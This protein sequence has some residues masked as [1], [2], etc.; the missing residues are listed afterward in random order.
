MSTGT[1]WEE[2]YRSG[3]LPWD[4]G[5]ASPALLEALTRVP[6]R[7][8]VLV[9]GCGLGHDVRALAAAGAEVVGLDLSPTGLRAA[10]A[11]PRVGNEQ[12]VVGNFFELPE[13]LGDGVRIGAV[14]LRLHHHRGRHD[15]GIFRDR[16]LRHRDQPR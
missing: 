15:L 8:R 5:A 16:Q 6:I 10:E 12:Y 7:G 4:K 3:D 1:D 14:E 9:P 2:H 11:Q 13:E